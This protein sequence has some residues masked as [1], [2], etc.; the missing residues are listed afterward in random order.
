MSQTIP[1]PPAEAVTELCQS[2]EPAHQVMLLKFA[3]FLK[4]QEAQADFEEVDEE[5]E[6]EWDKLF[7]DPVKT[8]AMA[9][10]AEESMARSRPEPIDPAQL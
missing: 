10:W 1:F 7:S 6:A 8:A 2:L 3:Q 4:T 5:D 9:R